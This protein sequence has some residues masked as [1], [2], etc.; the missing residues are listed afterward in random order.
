MKAIGLFEH[1]GVSNHPSDK[2]MA[3]IADRIMKAVTEEKY[4]FP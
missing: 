3:A 1:T 2:G 4:L